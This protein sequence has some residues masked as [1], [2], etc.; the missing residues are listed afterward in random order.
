MQS[1]GCS[2]ARL[3]RRP[4]RRPVESEVARTS[5]LWRSF[6]TKPKRPPAAPKVVSQKEWDAALEQVHAKE[7]ALTRK[8]DALAAERRRLPRVRI[9]K[10]YVFQ[11]P[12]GKASLGD[13]FD[14]R[15]Q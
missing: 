1:Y 6:M 14:G 8:H 11:G 9:D 7:K 10:D 5:S 2:F 15:R 12:A 4:D 3:G 13:L